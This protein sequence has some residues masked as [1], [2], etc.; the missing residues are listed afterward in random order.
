M[1]ALL[2]QLI[3]KLEHLERSLQLQ[4]SKWMTVAE[5]S[6]Y[7]RISESKMRKLIGTGKISINR[8]DG[9]IL[10]NKKALDFYILLGTSKPNKRQRESVECLF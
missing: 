2:N 5:S 4:N 10:L 7:C 6:E 1:E 8:I 9:K 3:E